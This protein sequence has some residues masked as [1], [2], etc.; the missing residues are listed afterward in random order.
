MRFPGQQ[1]GRCPGNN[2]AELL[3]RVFNTGRQTAQKITHNRSTRIRGSS[4]DPALSSR[5]IQVLRDTKQLT[6][7]YRRYHLF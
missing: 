7:K 1:T 4:Y 2:T 6:G 5:V 3:R